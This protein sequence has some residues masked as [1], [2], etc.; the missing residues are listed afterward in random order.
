LCH[1]QHK[2]QNEQTQAIKITTQNHPARNNP[3]M[4]ATTTTT[5]KKL[6]KQTK[7]K[8]QEI[9]DNVTKRQTNDP[10]NK[11]TN[12]NIIRTNTQH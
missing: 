6:T 12:A 9:S 4:I 10:T 8:D 7:M 2:R 5:N 1:A 11:Q 3:T